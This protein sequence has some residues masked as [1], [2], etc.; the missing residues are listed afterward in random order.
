MIKTVICSVGISAARK[1]SEVKPRSLNNWVKDQQSVEDAA[2]KIFANFRD[3]APEGESLKSALSAE[4]HSLVRIGIT[5]Q[6]RIILF[7]LFL[8]SSLF[9]ISSTNRPEINFRPG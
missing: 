6:D 1:L 4:I 7:V 3:I 8:V 2:E 9:S 5:D